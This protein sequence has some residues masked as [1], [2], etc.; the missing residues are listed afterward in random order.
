M[1]LEKIINYMAGG[2][3]LGVDEKQTSQLYSAMLGAFTGIV[4]FIDEVHSENIDQVRNDNF[5]V[6]VVI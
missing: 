5:V 1:L 6:D 3:S 4:H 2:P